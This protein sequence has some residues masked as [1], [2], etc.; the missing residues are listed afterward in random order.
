[1]DLNEL[2]SKSLSYALS[3]TLS[4]MKVEDF[5]NVEEYMKAIENVQTQYEEALQNIT[6]G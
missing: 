2:D 3:E 4:S 1:M 5:D 6:T